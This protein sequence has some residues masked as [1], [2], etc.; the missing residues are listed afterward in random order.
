MPRLP[1]FASSLAA[2]VILGAHETTHLDAVYMPFRFT[3][4]KEAKLKAG[5]IT[6]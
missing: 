4:N 1:I 5:K 2:K 6:P 3:Q